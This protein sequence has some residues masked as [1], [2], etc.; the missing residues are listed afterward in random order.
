MYVEKTMTRIEKALDNL[1]IHS[2]GEIKSRIDQVSFDVKVEETR[3]VAYCYCLRVDA[4]GN[5][6]LKDLIEF[7][8][9][10]IVEYAIP[11]KEINE[12]K[13]YFDETG[14]PAKVQRLRKK[15]ENLFT[16]LEKTGEGGEILLYILVQE[17]LKLPQLISKMSLKTSGKLHYQGA[18]GIHVGYDKST[19]RLNLFWGESKMYS[20]VNDAMD[21]CLKSIK[22]YL[23]DPISSSSVHERD[24]QLITSNINSNINDSELEDILV[25]YFDKDDDLSNQLEYKGLCFIGFD[26]DKYPNGGMQKTTEEIKDDLQKEVSKW[27]KSLSKKIK[28]HVN[29]ELKEIHVFLMPFPSVAEFRKFYL[30]EIK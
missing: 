3:A 29:L 15:A 25:R 4:N 12:A 9:E 22:S 17:F 16:D 27:Y 30:N 14:S 7:I 20:S 1:L 28:S 5:L 24:M 11:L 21:K 26:S 8:D 13:K 19:N 10:K 6:R 2:K 23:L 18:D